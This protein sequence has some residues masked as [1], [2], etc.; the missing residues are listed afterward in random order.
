VPYLI[1]SDW[2]VDYLGN[3]PAAIA[4]IDPLIPDG[5]AISIITYMEAYQGTL[6][7]ADPTRAAAEL[8]AFLGQA[9]VLPLSLEVAQRC[10]QLREELS[11]QRKRTRSRA[12]DLLI[13]ATA[14]HYGL[15]LVTR[16]RDDY[17]DI[18]GLTLH[19]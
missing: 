18:D 7:K 9:P 12:L 10:A 8:A 13:A 17:Q 3:D 19:P 1:D 11:R 5:V 2:L 6:R 15:T 4:H 14:L 16:N